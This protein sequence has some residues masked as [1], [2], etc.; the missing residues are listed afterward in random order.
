MY[1]NKSFAEY[2]SYVLKSEQIPHT[3]IQHWQRIR[4]TL[5]AEAAEIYNNSN[6][7]NIRLMVM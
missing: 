3:Y 2:V 5:I 7:V 1:I 6:I 4:Y